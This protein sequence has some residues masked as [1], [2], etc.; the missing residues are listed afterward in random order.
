[1]EKQCHSLIV[2]VGALVLVVGRVLGW[3]SE[4][5]LHKRIIC[6]LLSN[7]RPL[8]CR[9]KNKLQLRLREPVMLLCFP[10]STRVDADVDDS[11]S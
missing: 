5:F 6:T 3:S 9:V 10:G 2:I 4:Y 8:K 7:C 1:M 11:W